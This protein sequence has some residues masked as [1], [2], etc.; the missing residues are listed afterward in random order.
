MLTRDR[1]SPFRGLTNPVLKGNDVLGLRA[2]LPFAD[3]E[4]NLLALLQST[5]ACAFDGAEVDEHVAFAFP[6]DEPVT[7]RVIEPL[8]CSYQSF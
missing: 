6:G 2:F 1:Q 4:L 5:S 8:D 7:L 3:R